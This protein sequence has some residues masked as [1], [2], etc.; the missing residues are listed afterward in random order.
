MYTSLKVDLVDSLQYCLGLNIECRT[1]ENS[2]SLF[3][4]QKSFIDD[5]IEQLSFLNPETGSKNTP[6]RS[7]FLIDK[8]PF[9]NNLPP[10]SKTSEW[11][12]FKYFCWIL[13]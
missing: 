2:K 6:F 4:F 13:K 9:I 3:I 5:L 8:M 1:H 7:G 12:T 11:I 10:I